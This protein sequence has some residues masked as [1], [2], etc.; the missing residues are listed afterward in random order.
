MCLSLFLRLAPIRPSSLTRSTSQYASKNGVCLNK[1]KVDPQAGGLDQDNFWIHNVWLTNEMVWDLSRIFWQR[2]WGCFN[3]FQ[4]MEFFSPCWS[5]RVLSCFIY[6]FE[7]GWSVFQLS[8]LNNVRWIWD[9]LRFSPITWDVQNHFSLAPGDLGGHLV[10]VYRLTK[11]ST[12]TLF[13]AK[14]IDIKI[15][16]NDHQ[17]IPYKWLNTLPL[18]PL[19]PHSCEEAPV[20]SLPT[21]A[22]VVNGSRSDYPQLQA[23]GAK[24]YYLHEMMPMTWKCPKVFFLRF[25]NCDRS[26]CIPC[27]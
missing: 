2:V 11:S 25:W 19:H 20:A 6:L 1:N 26:P 9:S 21:V 7:I 13:W 24:P 27:L 10:N 14:R 18:P 8:E 22:K 17:M 16:W 15:I 23:P 3:S 5:F 4:M 12:S